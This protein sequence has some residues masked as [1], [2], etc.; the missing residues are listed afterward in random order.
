MDDMGPNGEDDDGSTLKGEVTVA[1]TSTWLCGH[2]LFVIRPRLL[3]TCETV[4]TRGLAHI[5]RI[6]GVSAG[7]RQD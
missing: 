1:Q 5:F 3:L 7:A 2:N 6:A 4:S